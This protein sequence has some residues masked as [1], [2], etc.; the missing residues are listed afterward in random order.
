V[1]TKILLAVVVVA[2][3][4]GNALLSYGMK[5]TGDLSSLPWPQMAAASLRALF[6]PWVALGVALLIIYLAAYSTVLSWADLSYV[7]PATAGGYVLVAVFSW[8]F[9]HETLNSAR[10][11]GTLLITCGVAL[12]ARTGERST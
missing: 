7:L 10:W 12:V 6:N 8:F 3:A 2:S 1:K 4:S 11:T 5:Q 9:L